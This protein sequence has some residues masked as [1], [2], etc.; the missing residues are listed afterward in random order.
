MSRYFLLVIL[1]LFVPAAPAATVTLSTG[2]QCSYSG[3]TVNA[4]GNVTVT[5]AAILTPTPVPPNPPPPGPLPPTP[6]APTTGC[7]A[8]SAIV[9]APFTFTGEKFVFALQPG[10]SVA[11]PFTPRAGT[12]P[13]LST[14]ETVMTPPNADH[15][16]AVS[17]C[18]G[19]F[20]PVAPCRYDAN[21]IGLSMPV[22]PRAPVGIE[23]YVYCPVEP[24]VTYYMNIRQVVRGNPQFNSCTQ[25]ACEVRAQIQ[26]YQ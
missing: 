22:L 21:Y 20:S 26:A 23:R 16:V 9:S 19:D 8:T 5:C 6:P 2:A 1:A 3:F 12:M 25:D 24:N 17:R 7:S 18:P 15:Q 4:S 13:Q 11:I 10:Q 14:T